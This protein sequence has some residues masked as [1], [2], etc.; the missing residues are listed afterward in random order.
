MRTLLTAFL[1][2]AAI[3]AIMAITVLMTGSG[4][5]NEVSIVAGGAGTE[6]DSGT[7]GDMGDNQV[8]ADG[9]YT[10]TDAEDGNSVLIDRGSFVAGGARPVGIRKGLNITGIVNFMNR[11]ND[12]SAD[13]MAIHDYEVMYDS[14]LG[15]YNI[16]GGDYS[17][18]L[19]LDEYGN[20]MFATPDSGIGENGERLIS[21]SLINAMGSGNPGFSNL[22]NEIARRDAGMKSHLAGIKNSIA[23]FGEEYTAQYAAK[24]D[25]EGDS[26]EDDC[27]PELPTLPPV[28]L[29]TPDDLEE[30]YVEP[31]AN[32]DAFT[33]NIEDYWGLSHA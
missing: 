11:Y 30:P 5:E 8:G 16:I 10:G 7:S 21:S 26:E 1:I 13:G 27:M 15:V 12:K 14:G 19:V 24:P 4:A 6:P 33:L 31:M 29:F 32:P 18:A 28:R 23:V 2:M 17:M 20:V 9:Q 25:S 3:A 22:V